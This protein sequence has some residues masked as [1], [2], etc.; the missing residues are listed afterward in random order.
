MKGWN[1]NLPWVDQ[2]YSN[3]IIEEQ[4]SQVLP[5]IVL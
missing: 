2:L 5:N 4:E 1:W 3:K